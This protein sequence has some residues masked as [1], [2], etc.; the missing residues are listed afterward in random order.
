MNSSAFCLKDEKYSALPINTS[1]IFPNKKLF[2]WFFQRR[3]QSNWRKVSFSWEKK[4]EN[5]NGR[6]NHMWR[7][8]NFTDFRHMNP[9]VIH[10]SKDPTTWEWKDNLTLSLN[11]LKF[12]TVKTEA[13]A[14]MTF[15]TQLSD[16]LNGFIPNG[17]GAEDKMVPPTFQS[18]KFHALIIIIIGCNY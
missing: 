10:W 15:L 7:N 11:R 9:P 1:Y 12:Q 4:K 18:L 16:F 2:V 14:F 3:S 6:G 8:Y 17:D 5:N 13:V